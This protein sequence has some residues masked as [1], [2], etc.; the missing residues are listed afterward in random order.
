MKSE[1]E[2]SYRKYPYLGSYNGYVVLFIKPQSGFYVYVPGDS[3]NTTLGDYAE[4]LA[5]SCFNV[6]DGNIIL[7]N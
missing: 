2:V 1:K 5:E 4:D 6:F 7:E 3:F